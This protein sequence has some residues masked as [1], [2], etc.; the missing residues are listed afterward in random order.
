M[1]VFVI[2][3]ALFRDYIMHSILMEYYGMEKPPPK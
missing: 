3:S 2:S 1:P